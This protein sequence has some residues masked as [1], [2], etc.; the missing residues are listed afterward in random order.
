MKGI[1]IVYAVVHP[2]ELA[3]GIRSYSE[4]VR[5]IVES[6]DPGGDEEEFEKFMRDCL[7]EWFDGASVWVGDVGEW[8][9]DYADGKP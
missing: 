6:G 1:E 5:V 9:E 2:G 7:A 4:T 3:A 8:D